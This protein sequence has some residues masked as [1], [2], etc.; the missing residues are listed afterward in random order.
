MR[1]QY[2]FRPSEQGLRAWDVHRLIALSEGLPVRR[3][4]L[5]TILELDEV[6]WFDDDLEHPTCRKVLMHLGLIQEADL[7]YPILLSSDGRVMDGM[8]RVAKA[9]MEQRS[10]IDAIRFEHDPEPDYV[11][12]RPSELP[13][14]DDGPDAAGPAVQP[15]GTSDPV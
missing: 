13:Y 1:K 12:K 11:G 14:D 15:D 5:E 9:V 6:Y 4:A 2:H 8:H 7:R 3:V 10:E